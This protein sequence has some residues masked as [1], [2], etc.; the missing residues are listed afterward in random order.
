MNKYQVK[1]QASLHADLVSDMFT[2][3]DLSF[4]KMYDMENDK[5]VS[6]SA[7]TFRRSNDILAG[8]YAHSIAIDQL[9]GE[10]CID[11]FGKSI[12][13]KLAILSMKD[14]S[15]SQ[16]NSLSRNDNTTIFTAT[17]A[18][19]SVYPTT[20]IDHHAKNTAFVL[21]SADH[22]Q[23]IT[24]FMM[25]GE[26]VKEALTGSGQECVDRKISLRNFIDNGYEFGSR[27]PHMGFNNYYEKAW[28]Y[29]AARQGLLP[30][31]QAIKAY[32]DWV[33]L[34]NKDNL[35]RL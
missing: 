3:N 5:M 11:H 24:G 31:I 16:S 4:A 10:D 34:S 30:K 14:F 23:F 6:F 19:F 8:S 13:L 28:Y 21:F 2:F 22:N 17:A 35:K 32:S 1:E 20:P 27:V 15:I 25:N 26:N 7:N 12:E 18:R 33:E 9:Y 29:V